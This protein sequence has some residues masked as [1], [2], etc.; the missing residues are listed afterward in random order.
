MASEQRLCL[1]SRQELTRGSELVTEAS[2]QIIGLNNRVLDRQEFHVFPLAAHE[3]IAPDHVLETKTTGPTGHEGVGS[4]FDKGL[5]LGRNRT[6]GSDN[7]GG[8]SERV[9]C[10]DIIAPG[11]GTGHRARYVHAPHRE[12]A[13]Y[14]R[15]ESPVA[16]PARP[17]NVMASL[18]CTAARPVSVT[19]YVVFTPGGLL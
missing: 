6:S 19:P 9:C 17:L 16:H 13:E 12:A 8:D 2:A 5:R 4:L 15:Q 18:T 11:Y 14:I 7:D 10:S 1:L 3:Q